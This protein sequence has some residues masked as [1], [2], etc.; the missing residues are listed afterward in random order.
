MSKKLIGVIVNLGTILLVTALCRSSAAQLVPY[1]DFQS[2]AINPDKWN[3]SQNYDP[4]LREAVRQIVR[5][6]NHGSLRLTQTAYSAT[7]D[8][9]G[10]SGGVFGL[11]FAE[12]NGIREVSFTVNV[13][14][15]EAVGCS[16]NDSLIVTDAEFRGTFFNTESAPTSQIGNVVAVIDLE[17]SPANPGKSLVVSGFLTRCEDQFCSS[18]SS[19]S[20]QV[21]GS[22]LFGQDA[23]LHLKWDQPN[24]RFVF[25]LNEDPEVSS[26]YT[27]SDTS[28]AVS[29]YKAIDLA[30]VVPHCTAKNRPRTSMDVYLKDVYINQ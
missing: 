9:A 12:P 30:R 16:S 5:G 28:P 7:T 18:Q 6:K 27:V 17:R 23:R 22:V 13:D 4:D 15:A 20:Y 25:Q 8:D 2:R 3:G 26:P 24:H 10:G 1:D 29:P 19:L 11:Q 14:R 21:L